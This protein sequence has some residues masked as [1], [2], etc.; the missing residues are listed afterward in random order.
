MGY[1]APNPEESGKEDGLE[2]YKKVWGDSASRISIAIPHTFRVV[3]FLESLRFRQ[4]RA[5]E[6]LQ[7]MCANVDL[8]RTWSDKGL[9]TTT[10]C[11]VDL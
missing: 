5:V 10:I 11:V 3:S 8:D 6:L 4:D 9:H 1:D 2:M 7:K